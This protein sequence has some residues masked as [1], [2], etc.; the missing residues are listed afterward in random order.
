MSSIRIKVSRGGHTSSTLGL[1]NEGKPDE[2]EID[3]PIPAGADTY[4]RSFVSP[5][6]YMQLVGVTFDKTAE[7]VDMVRGRDEVVDADIAEDE[8]VSA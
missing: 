4:A 2:I 5:S 8:E 7:L 6:E 3:V 1:K